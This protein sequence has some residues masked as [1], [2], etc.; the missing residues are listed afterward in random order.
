[1]INFKLFGSL[2][3]DLFYEKRGIFKMSFM[4]KAKNGIWLYDNERKGKYYR[5]KWYYD[6]FQLF[7][8][9]FNQS[10]IHIHT[11]SD[12]LLNCIK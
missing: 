10:F 9:C 3:I 7:K 2:N 12:S 8:H 6:N 5:A 4:F 11:I 1:M